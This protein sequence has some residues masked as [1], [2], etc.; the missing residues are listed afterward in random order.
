MYIEVKNSIKPVDY[1]EA[2]KVLEKRVKDVH[3]GKKSELLWI[4][5]HNTIFTAGIRSNVSDILNKNIKVIKTNRGGKI[6]LH[7]PGQKIAYFVLNLN[8][9]NKD[10]RKLINNVEDCIID[11]LKEYNIKSYKDKKNIGIW[12]KKKR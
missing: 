1:R 7:N 6:T 3:E 4:L 11:V 10:I 8:K 5:E 9:R 12:V 2:M